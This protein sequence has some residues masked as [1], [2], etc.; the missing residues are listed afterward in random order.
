MAGRIFIT[1]DT[2]GEPIERL[3]RKKFKPQRELDRNDYIIIC[4]DFGVPW[5]NDRNMT[6]I[7]KNLAN[8][9]FTVLFIDGNHENFDLLN[10]FPIQERFGGKVQYIS[11]NIIH[12]MRGEYYNI[13][14]KTFW[15]FGG[16][17]SHDIDGG[18]LDMNDP[19]FKMK[20]NF[21]NKKIKETNSSKY[22]YRINHIDWWK[23]EMPTPE[24]MKNGLKN[25]ERHRNK[26]DYII[27]HCPPSSINRYYGFYECDDLNNYFEKIKN[28]VEYKKWYFGHLHIN[29]AVY[30]ERA[31]ALYEDIQEIGDFNFD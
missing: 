23:E 19:E 4:G 11:E 31:I 18:V 6:Y 14:G 3:C 24:E 5:Q 2:H 12:L 10:K 16:A 13:A 7:L 17:R 21:L 26:V 15:V 8:R 27:T 1:G 25:L 9:N 22:F 29:D 28:M 20:M 30:W